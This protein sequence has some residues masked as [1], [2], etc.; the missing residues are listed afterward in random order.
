MSEKALLVIRR[1]ET[2]HIHKVTLL[3]FMLVA[4][5]H[6][7]NDIDGDE[8]NSWKSILQTKGFAVEIRLNGLGENEKIRQIYVAHAQLALECN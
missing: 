7:L 5:D 1:L 3:P 8:P 2:S 4:G 6:A